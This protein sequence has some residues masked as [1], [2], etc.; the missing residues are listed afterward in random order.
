M[1]YIYRISYTYIIH[2]TYGNTYIGIET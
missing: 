2:H 1:S